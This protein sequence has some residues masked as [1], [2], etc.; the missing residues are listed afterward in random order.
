M[1]GIKAP[2]EVTDISI[3]RQADAIFFL[4]TFIRKQEWT[5]RRETDLPPV[6][7]QYVVHYTDQTSETVDVRY[8][9]GVE[10][11]RQ[12]EPKGLRDATLAWASEGAAVY[13]L[14]W[15]NPHP[16]K[17]IAHIDLRYEPRTGNRYGTP[18]VLGISTG[19]YRS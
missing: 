6:L 13:A 12:E 2:G 5:P 1:R 11:W 4:H 16:D 19:A 3:Q 18:V 15:N 8:G 7:F 9:L 17:K 14:Q 10:H